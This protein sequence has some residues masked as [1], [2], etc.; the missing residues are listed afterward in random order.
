MMRWSRTLVIGLAV[1][2]YG[3]VF[4]EVFLRLFAPEP[5]VPRYVTGGS[6][7]IRA[8]LP[9]VAFRQW[10]PEVDVVVR[11]NERGMRDDRP[12]PALRKRPGECRVA[13]VGDSYFVGF[14]SDFAG[15]FGKRLEDRL[16]AAKTPVRVLDFAVSGFGT[17]EDLI[18]IKRRVAAWQPDVVIMSWHASDPVDN[19]RSG[20]FRVEGGRLVATG[21]AF[22]PGVAV[23]DRLMLMPGYRWLIENSHLYSAVRE[24]AGVATKA[25][26]AD[27]RGKM[28]EA[29]PGDA[30]KGDTAVASMPARPVDAGSPQL[31][32]AL[33]MAAR[34]ASHAMGAQF[35]LFDIPIRSDRT[36]FVSPQALYLGA[37][38]GIDSVSPFA[39]F[40]AAARP[41]RKLYQEHGQLHWTTEGNAR[42]AAVAAA[43]IG[44]R[45]WL[46]G[47][48]DA[49]ARTKS[50][51][52][53]AAAP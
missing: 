43:D 31:D 9:N 42:A 45:G 19:V 5:L 50:F 53:A 41:D 6:D 49:A 15:S 20:L 11:Y 8:N 28:H 7:G 13:L 10:T 25:L 38:P 1:V 3:L 2:A 16:A 44:Q 29:S 14:E 36:T 21:E 24:R 26:L 39:D 17:A 48:G 18:V 40:K 30:D 27:V 32:L 34:D 51:E 4:G 12:A 46:R 37:L 22:L 47:C 52:I 23:S 35:L 33:L